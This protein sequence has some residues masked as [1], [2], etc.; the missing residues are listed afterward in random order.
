MALTNKQYDA[1]M[2]EYDE[3]RYR[4]R[5]LAEKRR[6]EI[7][8]ALPE[9]KA[10]DNRIATLSVKQ[11]MSELDDKKKQ[12]EDIADEISMLRIRRSAE[13]AS[14]GFSDNDLEP[15]YTC[16]FCEDTGYLVG[17]LGARQK[18]SCFKKRELEILYDQSGVREM[19]ETENF[20]KFSYEYCNDEDLTRLEKAVSICKDFVANFDTNYQNIVFCGTVGAGKSY[21]SCCIAYELLQQCHSVIY[22]SAQQLFETMAQYQFGNDR[23]GKDEFSKD[24]YDCELLIID[25]LGT[26]MANAFIASSLFSIIN[27]RNLR[28]R[29]TIISTNLDFPLISERYSERV[30]SR[31]TGGYDFVGLPNTDVR[32]KIKDNQMQMNKEKQESNF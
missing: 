26:E 9:I 22:F 7:E 17:T 24:I 6:L 23:E 12:A 4:N 3:I 28:R 29:A 32:Q 5:E 10:F 1:I 31:L 14:A 11:A 15:I 21:L 20:S 30:L 19:L 25:D 18:C 2:R 8:K 27:E 16:K 13:L